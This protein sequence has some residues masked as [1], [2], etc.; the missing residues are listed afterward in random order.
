[1]EDL[2][3]MT[4][5]ATINDVPSIVFLNFHPEP[6]STVGST[7]DLGTGYF[8]IKKKFAHDNFELDENGRVFS[9]RVENLW[10]M[11]K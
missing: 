11:E 4:A 10:E 3:E 2:E 1:M 7:Q 6:Q 5:I 9:K 8:N